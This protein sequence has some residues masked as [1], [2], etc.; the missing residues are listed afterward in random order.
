MRTLRIVFSAVLAALAASCNGA[1]AAVG[2][3]TGGTSTG[4]TSTGGTSTGGTSTGG[5]STGGTSTGGTSTG[6][7]STGGTSTGGD[8]GTDAA[9][10][11]LCNAEWSLVQP[12]QPRWRY[13]GVNWDGLTIDGVD[14][15]PG[16]CQSKPLGAFGACPSGN[17]TCDANAWGDANEVLVVWNVATRAVDQVQLRLGYTGGM[18]TDVYPDHTGARHA[19]AFT[20]GDVLRRDGL[21]FEIQWTDAQTRAVQITDI[22][23]AVM[24]TYAG[25]AGMPF[26][27]TTCTSDTMCTAP[28]T[29]SVCECTHT[30]DPT[31]MKPTADCE[32][33]IP[34]GGQCGIADCGSD[35]NCLIDDDGSTTTFGILPLKVY[36]QGPAG[37]AQPALSTPQVVYGLS[38]SK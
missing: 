5:S 3:S 13:A 36:V 19:Y 21:P 25:P 12:I 14:S 22:F 2:D 27:T 4:G 6:G 18:L 33:T 31:T 37:V 15:A 35:G 8:A 34:N 29:V 10:A 7:T 11:G 24:A 16:L 38:Y 32:T 23:N 17:G 28:G 26:D 1:I 20:I 30:I 9:D